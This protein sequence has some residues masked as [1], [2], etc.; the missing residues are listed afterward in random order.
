MPRVGKKAKS[1]KKRAVGVARLPKKKCC[2][3]ATRCDRCPLRMLKEGTLPPGYTVH[4]R[5]LLTLD[6]AARRKSAKRAR[7]AGTAA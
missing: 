4:K 2:E 3:S 6:E 5:R 7:K 1:R